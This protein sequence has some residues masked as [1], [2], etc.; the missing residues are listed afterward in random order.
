MK[1]GACF[2]IGIGL[3]LTQLP[4]AGN[5]S[6]AA[7]VYKTSCEKC[8]AAKGICYKGT[9][10]TEWKKLKLSRSQCKRIVTKEKLQFWGDRSKVCLQGK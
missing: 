9:C 3:L 7:K 1:M 4:I 8:W 10:A 6:A 5:F 2:A